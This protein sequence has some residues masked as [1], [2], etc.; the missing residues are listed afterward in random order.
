[1]IKLLNIL[2]ELGVNN[3]NKTAEEVYDYWNKHLLYNDSTNDRLMWGE[4]MKI[5]SNYGTHMSSLPEF[6]KLSQSDLNKIY[7]EMKQLVQK[8]K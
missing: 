8:N 1:M 5:R 2:N 3:P 4:W 7:K 6:Q